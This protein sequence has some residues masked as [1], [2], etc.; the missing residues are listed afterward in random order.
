MS[1]RIPKTN[2]KWLI[3]GFDNGIILVRTKYWLE[4]SQFLCNVCEHAYQNNIETFSIK[5]GLI[6]FDLKKNIMNI[7][8]P[9]IIIDYLQIKRSF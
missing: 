5:D 3:K 1:L 9:N 8:D 6:N 4:M 2:V 7:D